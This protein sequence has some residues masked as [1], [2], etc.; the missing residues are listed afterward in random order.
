MGH[1]LPAVACGAIT[2]RLTHSFVGP[3]PCLLGSHLGASL[4]SEGFRLGGYVAS[5]PARPWRAAS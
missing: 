2:R 1:G 3:A 5:V 4:G